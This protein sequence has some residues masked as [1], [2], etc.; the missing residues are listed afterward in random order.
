MSKGTSNAEE[1]GSGIFGVLRSW[2][3]H[4]VVR[5]SAI[6]L[7]QSLVAILVAVV[8]GAILIF[9]V[10]E[11][12]LQAY[13]AM[14]RGA[15]I[16]LPSIARTLRMASPL[17]ITGLAVVVAFRAG[18][19][20][21]GMEGS[22]YIGALASALLAIYVGNGLPV[23]LQLPLALIIGGAAGGAWAFLPAYL[24]ARLNI[25]EVV[26]TL[27]LNYIAVLVVDHL[28]YTYFQ[29]PIDGS[30]AERALT[31][32]IPEAAR[33]PFLL[34]DYGLTAS[35]I[36]GVVLVGIFMWVYSRSVWGYES[37]MTGLNRRFA[38]YGGVST[39]KMAITSMVLSGIL[40]G[41]AG[42]TES[43]G[44]YGRYVGGFS[45][46]LGFDGV[47]VALMGRLTPLGTLIGAIFFG[48]LKNGGTSMEMAVNVPRDLVIVVQGL[49]L[50]FVTA[51]SLFVLLKLGRHE[52]PEE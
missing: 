24:K 9:V 29:D 49:I 22:L 36:V 39:F 45:A 32:P 21:L 4:P 37:V 27:M 31:L 33:L 34:E 1:A 18:F 42:A 5:N 19:I 38:R 11:D 47:T 41:L 13:G 43:L 16:G 15:F 10:G 30:N 44:I 14:F 23:V 20:Y 52:R 48:A 3:D 50:L 26:A 46:D 8:I 7:L 25:D 35:I 2:F 12:P 28:V 6:N 40:A 17:I 51:Q